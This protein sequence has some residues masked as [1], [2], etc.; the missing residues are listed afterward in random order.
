MLSTKTCWDALVKEVRTRLPALEDVVPISF[1]RINDE[2]F[3]TNFPGLKLPACLVVHLGRSTD[4]M[5]QARN[6]ETRWNAVFI[7]RDEGGD[8]W[9]GATGLVDD[10]EDN[11]L[12]RQIL[13]DE[14]T[15]HGSVQVQ[16][17]YS[18]QRFSIYQVAFTTRQAEE[19]E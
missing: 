4:A 17:A 7:T 2:K 12:D 5:G 14:L 3:L 1:R 6:R 13:D 9:E 18:A 10:F 19:R 8:A 15:I 16:V 11:V